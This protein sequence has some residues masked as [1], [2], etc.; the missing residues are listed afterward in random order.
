[1]IAKAAFAETEGNQDGKV[2]LDEFIAACLGQE[3]FSKMLT[4]K[5]IEI[6]VEN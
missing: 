1:M 3:G 4:L 5:I 2:T 6:F